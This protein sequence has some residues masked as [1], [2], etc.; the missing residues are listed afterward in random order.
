V[1]RFAGLL[2]SFLVLACAATRTRGTAP[3]M[4]SPEAAPTVRAEEAPGSGAAGGP[5]AAEKP[6]SGGDPAMAETVR[7]DCLA[8]HSEE[9]L[10]QQ[11]LTERQWAKT[12]EKMRGWGAPTPAES[13]DRLAAYLASATTTGSGPFR[14]ETLTAA[15]AA[16]LFSRLPEGKLAGGS[17]ERGLDLYRDRCLACHAEDGRGGPEGVGLA[18]RRVLDRA[19]EFAKTVREGRGRMPGFA[20]TTDAETADLLAYL[21]SLAFP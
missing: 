13:V 16:S 4:P 14:A 12:I 9:L 7:D 18:G 5:G 15:D 1:R 19:P 20:D 3:P 2:A 10:R 6:S 21:R 17:A 8:C 11:R